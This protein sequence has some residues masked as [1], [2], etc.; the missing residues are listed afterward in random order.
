MIVSNDWILKQI[1]MMRTVL[2]TM[3]GGNKKPNE[4]ED[5]DA[6]TLQYALHLLL[7]DGQI[8]EAE[9]VLFEQL[10]ISK[11]HM[12]IVAISFYEELNKLTDMELENGNFSREEIATGLKDVCNEL[13]FDFVS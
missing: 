5:R 7:K 6:T 8:N 11:P 9:N 4:E 13:G 10:D 12:A 3:T 2:N 1:E